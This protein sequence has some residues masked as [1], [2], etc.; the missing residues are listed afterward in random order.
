MAGD[1]Q[2]SRSLEYSQLMTT[3][4]QGHTFPQRQ[5]TSMDGQ[6]GGRKAPFLGSRLDIS[7][8]PSQLNSSHGTSNRTC[9]TGHFPPDRHCSPHPSKGCYSW[10]P[11][12][13]LPQIP[14]S[15]SSCQGS[16]AYNIHLPRKLYKQQIQKHQRILLQCLFTL[17]EITPKSRVWFSMK[18]ATIMQN[19]NTH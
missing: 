7:E 17:G 10:A 13:L 3:L 18:C 6:C 12:N 16:T 5:P 15:K 14:D 4:H 9:I 11:A 2:L 8:G 19:L 1:S